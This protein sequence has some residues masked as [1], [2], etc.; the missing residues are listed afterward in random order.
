[1]HGANRLA[2]NSLL[3]G[4]VFGARAAKAMLADDFRHEGADAPRSQANPMNTGDEALLEVFITRLRRS[5]WAYAGLLRDQS[6]LQQGIS[7]QAEC[8]A[9]VER[10]VQQGKASRRL[11][12]AQAL[13]R[14]ARAIL[15]SALARTESRGA[16]YRNDYPQRDDASFLKHSVVRANG[17]VAFEAW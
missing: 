16:H 12:E 5:M 13:C 10:F 3:E 14:I 9:D 8:E 6:M 11:Y 7:A 15:L 17:Q 2:S 4:L 1:V